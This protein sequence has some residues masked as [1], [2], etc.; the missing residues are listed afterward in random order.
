MHTSLCLSGIWLFLPSCEQAFERPLDDTQVRI[1]VPG[2]NAITTDTVPTFY[3]EEVEG[4]TGYRLQVVAPR[5]DS[6]V[7]LGVDTMVQRNQFTKKLKPDTYQWRVRAFNETSTS[8]Y[9]DTFT[10]TIK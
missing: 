5:F 2:N 4:A 3:W 7:R 9:S 6:L 1:W 10:L 8:L